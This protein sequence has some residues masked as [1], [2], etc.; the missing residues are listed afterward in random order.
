[1]L[2]S[3]PAFDNWILKNNTICFGMGVMSRNNNR[4]SIEAKITI[5]QNVNDASPHVLPAKF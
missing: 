5:L 3:T 4:H 2:E 1:M